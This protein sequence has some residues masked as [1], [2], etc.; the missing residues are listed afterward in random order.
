MRF[1][2]SSARKMNDNIAPRVIKVINE[3]P[4][5]VIALLS[6]ISDTCISEADPIN[7]AR[8]EFTRLAKLLKLKNIMEPGLSRMLLNTALA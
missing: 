8:P 4:P 1:V 7:V 5:N 3:K 6:G 2:T